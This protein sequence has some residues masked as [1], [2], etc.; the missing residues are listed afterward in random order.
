MS[1]AK[2][3]VFSFLASVQI[4][5]DNAKTSEKT[6]ETKSSASDSAAESLAAQQKFIEPPRTSTR[7]QPAAEAELDCDLGK[8][9]KCRNTCLLHTAETS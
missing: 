3:T 1:V 6:P 9:P 4:E 5:V 7:N 2:D 8:V